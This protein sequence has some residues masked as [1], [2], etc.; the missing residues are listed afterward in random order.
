M[1]RLV[2]AGLSVVPNVSHFTPAG[3][4]IGGNL[5]HI[6]DISSHSHSSFTSTHP[7]SLNR[8]LLPPDLSLKSPFISLHETPRATSRCTSQ[9]LSD[10]LIHLYFFTLEVLLTSFL[11]PS[12][13]PLSL[14]PIHP[15]YR[16]KYRDPDTFNNQNELPSLSSHYCTFIAS[17]ILSDVS[18]HLLHNT[19][20]VGAN[21]IT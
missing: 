8:S 4:Q 17:N 16:H 3:I 13:Y 6:I 19:C 18:S 20:F 2:R 14:S 12:P 11:P 1:T 9:Q 15:S 21:R 7:S 5:G 10:L